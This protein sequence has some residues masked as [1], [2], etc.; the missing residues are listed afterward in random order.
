[1]NIKKLILSI[2]MIV[3]I[4]SM[5]LNSFAATVN[6]TGTNYQTV[7]F[8][9]QGRNYGTL[10]G[11]KVTVRCVYQYAY[12]KSRACNYITNVISIKTYKDGGD[13]TF[14]V[15]PVSTWY[16]LED[17]GRYLHVIAQGT[18]NIGIDVGFVK[19]GA[20]GSYPY[21]KDYKIYP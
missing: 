13:P 21:Y 15:E 19:V 14:Y 1:M 6:P 8:D 7:S 2:V 17:G 10:F 12:D 3:S 11:G 5:Y 16:K 18:I 9:S 20:I 4:L